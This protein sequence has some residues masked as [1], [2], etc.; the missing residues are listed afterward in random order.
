MSNISV[1]VHRKT[2]D[3]VLQLE[4]VAAITVVMQTEWRPDEN[5]AVEEMLQHVPIVSLRADTEG[6]VALMLATLIATIR[7]QMPSTS[8]SVLDAAHTLA[9]LIDAK[10]PELQRQL[11]EEKHGGE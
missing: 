7:D 4:G 5:P 2:D 11:P 1:T 10:H 9:Y 8:P 3:D 6:Q